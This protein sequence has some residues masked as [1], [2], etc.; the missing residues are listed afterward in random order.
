VIKKISHQMVG[1]D[2]NL[3]DMKEVIY[4]YDCLHRDFYLIIKHLKIRS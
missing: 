1:L 3:S 2:R 4:I